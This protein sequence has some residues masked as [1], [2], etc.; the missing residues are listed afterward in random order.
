MVTHSNESVVDR[1]PYAGIRSLDSQ[2]INNVRMAGY[3]AIAVGLINARYHDGNPDNILK[4]LI[5]VLPGALILLV[6]LSA[7]GRTWMM[8]KIVSR[9]IMLA[10]GVLLLYSFL[11]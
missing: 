8:T 4:S 1:R 3:A 2:R 11:L 10:G 7:M 5:L 9:M 6:S